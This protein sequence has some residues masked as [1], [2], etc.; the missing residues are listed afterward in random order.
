MGQH[1]SGSVLLSAARGAVL[2]AVA[3]LGIAAASDPVVPDHIPDVVKD[4]VPDVLRTVG[5]FDPK[6]TNPCFR[7]PVDGSF[8]C[9]PYFNIIGLQFCIL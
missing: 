5:H 8:R 6:H 9:L 4:A 7:S 3:L 2:L 1:S